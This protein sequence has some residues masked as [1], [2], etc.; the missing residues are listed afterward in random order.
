MVDVLEELEVLIDFGR[1]GIQLRGGLRRSAR[2]ALAGRLRQ[3]DV[4]R[5]VGKGVVYLHVVVKVH[6][7]CCHGRGLE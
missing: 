7:A 4:G 1:D 3:A 5:N 6:H 2:A